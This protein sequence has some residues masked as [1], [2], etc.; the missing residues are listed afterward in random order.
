MAAR[1][2]ERVAV[3]E[4]AAAT[5]DS[6]DRL[7]I[8]LGDGWRVNVA[9]YGQAPGHSLVPH[10]CVAISPGWLLRTEPTSGATGRSA[11]AAATRVVSR[12]ARSASAEVSVL[13][14]SS[15]SDLLVGEQHGHRVVDVGDETCESSRT[16]ALTHPD[17]YGLGRSRSSP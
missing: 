15:Q 12:R 10:A 5:G 16:R 6:H 8:T 14:R 4:E 11:R 7:K 17:I 2:D 13:Y 1:G 3:E 9:A